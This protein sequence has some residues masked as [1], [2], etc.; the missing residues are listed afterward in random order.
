MS[1]NNLSPIRKKLLRWYD[2]NKRDLPWRRSRDPYAIWLA[3]TMLQQTQVKTVLPYYE[4]F[5]AAFPTAGALAQAPL[6]RVLR[7]WSGLGYYRRAENLHKAARQVMG[8]HRGTIP[9]VY[10][11]LRALA[12]IG[13]YTAGAILSI[14][15]EKPYPAVD[16]NVR[17]VL[18]RLFSVTG[19]KELRALA[20]KLVPKARPGDFNQALMELG[21]TVCT[22]KNQRC[23]E[24]PVKLECAG[25]E[26]DRNVAIDIPRRIKFE[27]VIWPLA[28]VRRGERI[29]LRRRAAKGLLA[30]LWE[31]PGSELIVRQKISDLLL[32][33][34]PGMPFSGVG[35]KK[36]GEFSHAITHRRIRAPIYLFELP[37]S[38]ALHLARNRWRWV[39][40]TRIRDHAVTSMTSKAVKILAG[41]EATSL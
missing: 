20:L 30:G 9:R 35:L 4:Q 32:A 1:A 33:H 7:L 6:E 23:G 21:A 2:N 13:D 25:R 15:F 22:P 5:L 31:L 8:E 37:V 34:L 16:G 27:N 40:P 41:H 38:D 28:I 12:G 39:D 18:G 29:L 24:C 19:E 14:A 26:R 3:E 17:R 10:D 36:I 11:Q